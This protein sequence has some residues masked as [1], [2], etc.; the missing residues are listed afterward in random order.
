MPITVVP[1]L[2]LQAQYKQ[3]KKQVEQQALEVLRSQVLI[4]G[5]HVRYLEQVLGAAHGYCTGIGCSSG[6]DGLLLSLMALD[7]GPGDEVITTPFTFFATAGAIARTGATPVFADI[8]ESTMNLDPVEVERRVTAKTKA[9]IPVHLFGNPAE[10]F[11]LCAIAR[12]HNLRVVEDAAQAIGAAYNDQ[13]VC[14]MGD[15][16]VL[17]FYPSKNLGGAGDGGMVLTS[18]ERLADRLRLLRN[19]GAEPKYHHWLVGG[20]FRLDELQAAILLAK[21]DWLNQ[22]TSHRQ[23][24]ATRY[25]WWFRNNQDVQPQILLQDVQ[26]SVFNQYVIRVKNRDALAARLKSH[27]VGTE[28]YYPVP[29]HLQKCF[30]HLGYK[31]GDLPVA[32]LAAERALALPIYP[33]LTTKQLDYVAKVVIDFLVP[34]C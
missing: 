34:P 31:P 19:H 12:R 3:V 7:I 13:P 27:G 1:F 25:T 24:N 22:W 8:R 32:E 15:C 26:H 23:N 11:E 21:F 18:N 6:T 10:M 28:V 14:S 5:P 2:D 4:N 33:E 9:I 30:A 29:L 16:G 17:S 20:N